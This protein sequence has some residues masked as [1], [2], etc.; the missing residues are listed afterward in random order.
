V[1][2]FEP[3]GSPVDGEHGIPDN[4]NGPTPNGV[5]QICISR[6]RSRGSQ[7]HPRPPSAA[8]PAS[9]GHKARRSSTPGHERGHVPSAIPGATTCP[10]SNRRAAT[11]GLP[12]HDPSPK[13]A[14]FKSTPGRLR[15]PP[16][17]AG[18]TRRGGH[19]P[20]ATNGDVFQAPSAARLRV[21]VRTGGQP[22]GA[23]P[24]WGSEWLIANAAILCVRY[25]SPEGATENS[26]GQVTRDA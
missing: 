14:G 18:D 21:P 8:T 19:P 5:E 7:I 26:P 24:T 2:P 12:L 15:R 6:P 1:S 16:P 9:G 10:R 13:T 3:E 22:Q 20:P 25:C 4:P 11:G 23:A 17:P